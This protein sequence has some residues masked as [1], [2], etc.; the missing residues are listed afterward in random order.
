MASLLDLTSREIEIL[1]LVLAG[2]T[3]KAIAAKF[4]ITEKTVEFHLGRIYT[5]IGVRTRVM[6]GIWVM[7]QGIEDETREIPS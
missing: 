2:Q 7:Q 1:R 4:W 5:K 3:N 6:A